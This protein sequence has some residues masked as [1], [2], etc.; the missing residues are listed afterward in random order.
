MVMTIDIDIEDVLDDCS[1][2]EIDYVINWLKRNDYI[3]N[4][5]VVSD[6]EYES[7]NIMDIEF[8]TAI[9]KIRDKRLNI[10]LEDE[11]LIKQIANKL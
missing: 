2:W 5:Y 9:D 7:D 1:S 6:N 8:K 11:A 4:N 3:K 10:S